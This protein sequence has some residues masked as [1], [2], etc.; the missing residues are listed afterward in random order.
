MGAELGYY[1][2][3]RNK[4]SHSETTEKVRVKLS[5][6]TTITYLLST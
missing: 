6:H 3:A 5:D 1:G 4:N 2:T